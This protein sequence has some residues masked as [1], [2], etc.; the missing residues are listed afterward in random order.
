RLVLAPL[1]VFGAF[2]LMGARGTAASI[3]LV[4]TAMPAAA[5][6]VVMAERYDQDAAFASQV[7]LATT[8]LSVLTIPFFA[9]LPL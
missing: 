8:L 9:G 7:V 6:S 5:Q 4:L 3:A 1:V 2:R